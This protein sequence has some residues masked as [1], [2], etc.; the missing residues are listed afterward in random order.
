MSAEAAQ[1]AQS[2]WQLTQKILFSSVGGVGLLIY[3]IHLLGEGLQRAAG[4]RLRQIL[5][6]FTSNPVKG[7]FV[8]AGA[9]AIIQSSSATTVMLVGFVNAGLMSLQQSFG[10]ILG[11]DIGTTVTVKLVA[12]RLE[13]YAL[14]AV[15]IGLAM[16][17]FAKRRLIRDIGLGL[18]GFGILFLGIYFLKDGVSAI[19]GSPRLLQALRWG[20]DHAFGGLA[21]AMVITAIVQSSSAT[22]AMVLALATGGVFGADPVTVI[23]KVLPLIL[24]C[25]IGTCITAF[26][27]SL[28][29]NV[30]ARRVAAAHI[31]FKVFGAL[32]AMMLLRLFAKVVLLTSDD[33]AQL[34]ANSHILFNVVNTAIFLPFLRY[35]KDLLVWLVPGEEPRRREL[36][37][38]DDLLLHAPSLAISASEQEMVHM[39]GI[40]REMLHDAMAGFVDGDRAAIKR[41]GD[42][43]DS[44]DEFQQKITEY[45]VRVS[46]QE[47]SDEQSEKLPA[48]IHIVNDLE[49][50]GDHAENLVE[51]A[52]AK[53]DGKL[54]FS[55]KALAE[56]RDLY[57]RIASMFGTTI[58]ALQEN[59]PEKAT[60]VIEAENE[61]NRLD[62]KLR[63]NHID[64]LK[65]GKCKVRGGVVFLDMLTNFEKVGD[66]LTNIAEAVGDALQWEAERKMQHD[67]S[68]APAEDADAP[69]IDEKS[70]KAAAE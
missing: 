32:W 9:T 54:K 16:H 38:L 43:E 44:V 47:L 25:N 64:R 46:Q 52:K 26:L 58:E 24:G 17:L 20:G 60:I 68:D 40:A 13:Q 59:D 36:Q 27:A 57:E 8:G 70:D 65:S 22:T 15:G 2:S 29:T 14:P 34:V 35:Y 61:I 42:E 19:K 10:V 30:S 6:A 12:F 63:G 53:L 55:K 28:G 51:L 67:N 18:L 49:R 3:G 56:L 50:I 66:H 69:S 48:L 31:A 41:V 39:A 37:Y 4:D 11:A 21:V 33:M 5:G 23:P 62:S 1:V 7:V 45:L